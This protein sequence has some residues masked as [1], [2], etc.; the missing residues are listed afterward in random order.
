MLAYRSLCPS[1][2]TSRWDDQR[3]MCSRSRGKCKNAI[4][5]GLHRGRYLPSQARPV[6]SSRK[7]SAACSDFVGR[8]KIGSEAGIGNWEEMYHIDQ[9]QQCSSDSR[10]VHDAKCATTSHHRATCVSM[11][12]SNIVMELHRLV[13]HNPGLLSNLGNRY[14]LLSP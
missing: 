14:C 11:T 12:C 2:W 8:E 6:D 13:D 4:T 9:Q 3:G 1:G 5:N 10:I 7:R